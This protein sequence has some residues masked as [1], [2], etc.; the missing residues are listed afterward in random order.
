VDVP[1]LESV[2]DELVNATLDEEACKKEMLSSRPG[3]T[4]EQ[5]HNAFGA[6]S[7]R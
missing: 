2:A 6:G 5:A 7:P 3:W 1:A 4:D